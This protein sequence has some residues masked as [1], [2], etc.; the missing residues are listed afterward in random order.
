MLMTSHYLQL[1]CPVV[2]IDGLVQE[3]RN[4]SALA[5]ELGL[6]CINPSILCMSLSWDELLE[7]FQ[8]LHP[9]LLFHIAALLGD[10]W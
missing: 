5:M 9:F 4:S 1:G 6:S 10:Y 2:H 8:A 3:R 7:K